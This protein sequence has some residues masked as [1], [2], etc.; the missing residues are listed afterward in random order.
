MAQSPSCANSSS[1]MEA[2]IGPCVLLSQRGED[3]LGVW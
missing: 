2:T 1:F 3:E